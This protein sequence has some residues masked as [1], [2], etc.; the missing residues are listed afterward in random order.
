MT[1][2]VRFAGWVLTPV[3]VCL[4]AFLFGWLG[5]AVGER[6]IWLVLGGLVGGL[7]AL[8]TWSAILAYV[9]KRQSTTD[10]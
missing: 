1:K 6:L 3:V 7:L 4:G 5:A 2:R 8:I 10:S 9:R